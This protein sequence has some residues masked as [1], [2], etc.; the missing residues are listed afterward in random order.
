MRYTLYKNDSVIIHGLGKRTYLH[1]FESLRRKYLDKPC[2]FV[3]NGR[4]YHFGL[5]ND[6]YRL[7]PMVEL[8][9]NLI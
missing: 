5:G 8:L 1:T 2:S 3:S 6:N 7:V 4:D 9:P